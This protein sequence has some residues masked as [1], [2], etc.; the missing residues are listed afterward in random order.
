M[1]SSI[2]KLIKV[3]TTVEETLK[4][5]IHIDSKVV[6]NHK[7]EWDGL[8]GQFKSHAKRIHGLVVK[9]NV[10]YHE[11]EAG[12]SFTSMDEIIDPEMARI[13]IEGI[14][15]LTLQP[16]TFEKEYLLTKRATAKIEVDANS[17]I[18]LEFILSFRPVIRNKYL[19]FEMFHQPEIV[20]VPNYMSSHKAALLLRDIHVKITKQLK[21]VEFEFPDIGNSNGLSLPSLSHLHVNNGVLSIFSRSQ[22]RHSYGNLGKDIK[23]GMY[24]KIPV[25]LMS[26]FI[27]RII[28]EVNSQVE[29]TSHLKL[30][31][32][33]IEYKVKFEDESRKCAHIWVLGAKVSKCGD[34][35]IDF[36]IFFDFQLQDSRGVLEALLLKGRLKDDSDIDIDN[37]IASKLYDKIEEKLEDVLSSNVEQIYNRMPASKSITISIGNFW[38]EKVLQNN[39]NKVYELFMN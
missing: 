17:T 20:A 37:D 28:S 38:V 19:R 6:S 5:V 31:P 29:L 26:S 8:N 12:V 7:E 10:A 30:K 25:S 3:S 1:N 2:E 27:K 21:F 36:K 32:N 22:G 15:E 24:L 35:D 16:L 11:L 4:S 23:N 18:E 39:K 9:K 14:D 33:G 34:I 13:N